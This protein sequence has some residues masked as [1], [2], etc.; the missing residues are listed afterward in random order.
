MAPAVITDWYL[1]RHA[2]VVGTTEGIQA[3]PD[4][5]A[6]LTDGAALARL[7]DALP[8]AAL[9]WSSPL[10]RCRATARA[11]LQA[12]AAERPVEVDDRL[13]EQHF[14]DLYG[15]S[16][17]D[18]WA[19][20]ERLPAHNWSMLAADSRPPGGGRFIDLWARVRDFI[21]DPDHRTNP[22]S[23][24]V[25]VAHAGVIRA[26]VGQALGLPPEIALALSA[27]PLSLCHLRASTGSGRG[28]AWQLVYMNRT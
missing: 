15:L 14:G 22:A 9:W 25:L 16:F 1:V 23:P 26:F 20:I 21:D 5:P 18:A 2:P 6:D 12:Q 3:S 27:E 10:Q 11:L 17:A 19:R 28:G 24:R 8:G 7:A 4:E 13:R